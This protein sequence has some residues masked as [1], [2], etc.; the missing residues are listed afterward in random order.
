MDATFE[1]WPLAQ[2]P[3]RTARQ[4]QK[5]V[6]NLLF[7]IYFHVS[8][9][10]EVRTKKVSCV[11]KT[12]RSNGSIGFLR[13]SFTH[14][15][16]FSTVLFCGYH[17]HSSC[18]GVFSPT[19]QTGVPARR[20]IRGTY[21]SQAVFRI[22]HAALGFRPAHKSSR[23]MYGGRSIGRIVVRESKLLLGTGSG[24]KKVPWS[25][26]YCDLFQPLDGCLRA[27]EQARPSTWF[28]PP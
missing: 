14:P 20:V 6:H 21:N 24:T 26:G 25:R 15:L 28:E 18:L 27:R 10:F 8:R 13:L 19:E 17:R 9:G 4:R 11:I 12:A 5:H 2:P 23:T 3:S 1:E 7:F 16:A 22:D